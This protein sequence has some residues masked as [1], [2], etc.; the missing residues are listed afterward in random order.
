MTVH[1]RSYADAGNSYGPFAFRVDRT[2]PAQPQVHVAPDARAVAAGWW[3][4]GPV[5]LSVS[6]A[7][8]PD[9]VS[10]RLRVYGPSGAVVF[11]ETAPPARSPPAR[12]PP[13]RSAPDGG[14]EADVVEC[15]IAGHCAGLVACGPALGR[16]VPPVPVDGTAPPLG[17]LAARDGAHMTWPDASAAAGGS[18][19]AGAFVGIGATAAAARAQALAA[20]SWKPARPASAR[21]RFRRRASVVRARSASPRGCSRGGHRVAVGGRSLRGGRRA[22][23]GADGDRGAGPGAAVRRRS[24]LAVSDA[25]GAAFSQVLVDGAP[26]A[27]PGGAITIAGE[28]AHV[29]RAVARDGAGN[30]TIVERALGVDAS[31]PSIGTAA[32]TSSPARCASAS[33][34]RSRASR[35]PRC[36]WRVRRSRRASRPTAAPRSRACPRASRSTAPPSRCASWT[37]PHLPMRASACRPCPHARCP[38]SGAS[39]SR[40]SGV[41]GRVGLRRACA[42]SRLGLSEGACAAP[43]RHLRDARRRYLRGARQGAPHDALR[44]RGAGE[45]GAARPGRAPGGQRARD[46]PHRRA[47]DARARNRLAIRAR[48]AGRGEAT[49]LHLLV[50]DVRGGRWVEACLERGRPGVR[51]E[52]TGRVWGSAASPPSARGSAWT[53]RLVLAAPSSTWPWRTPSSASVSLSCPSETDVGPAGAVER[54]SGEGRDRAARTWGTSVSIGLFALW[55]GW[56]GGLALYVCG[57]PCA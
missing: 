36:A 53:Y 8:A 55:V 15:D 2:A 9:V 40:P 30:E 57:R 12:Y 41:T 10:S 23:A 35:A 33:R 11:D 24:A 14:Y 39:A 18:G 1:A 4:H 29:L 16:A 51:L 17:L 38:S 49:R 44:G 32:P 42:G 6:T 37:P 28:G 13:P 56:P 5:T 7:T 48:F 3:G 43:R 50:H 21:P 22:A 52:R 26:V 31:A 25:S 27:V 46:R 20:T 47:A 45:P 54:L 19:I 34:M